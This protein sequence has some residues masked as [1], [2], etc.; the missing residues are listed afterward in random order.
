MDRPFRTSAQKPTRSPLLPKRSVLLCNPS[1]SSQVLDERRDAPQKVCPFV[2][3]V[4]FVLGFRRGEKVCPSVKRPHPQ[5]AG[6]AING[7]T[8]SDLSPKADA[9]PSDSVPEGLSVCVPPDHDLPARQKVCP[10]VDA[11]THRAS[12]N[13]QRRG[14]L[15]LQMLIPKAW[16]M[17]RAVHSSV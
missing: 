2:R 14:P 17:D 4:V 13:R 5:P 16:P 15:P 7:Q 9:P 3:F 6:A 1:F 8:I 10:L 12:V 11:R